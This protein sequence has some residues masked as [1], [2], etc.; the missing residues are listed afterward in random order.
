MRRSL[1]SANFC[2]YKIFGKLG[3]KLGKMLGVAVFKGKQIAVIIVFRHRNRGVG[4]KINHLSQLLGIQILGK[5]VVAI[6]SPAKGAH[7]GCVR[8]DGNRLSAMLLQNIL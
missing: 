7:G 4:A 2:L 1:F 6:P 5:N 8:K 3:G